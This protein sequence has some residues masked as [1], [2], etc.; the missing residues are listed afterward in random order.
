MAALAY[1]PYTREIEEMARTQNDTAVILQAILEVKETVAGLRS[2]VNNLNHGFNTLSGKVDKIDGDKAGRSELAATEIRFDRGFSTLKEEIAREVSRIGQDVDG[3]QNM[4]DLL[5]EE[6]KSQTTK[7]DSLIATRQSN[8]DRLNGFDERLKK[9][10]PLRDTWLQMVG[11]RWAV[12]TVGSVLGSGI[13][14]A[15][16]KLFRVL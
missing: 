6:S 1:L 16:L 14:L 12:G 2:D 15:I 11:A 3:F 13:T 7:L 4:Y 5:L 9:L 8:E 10:E